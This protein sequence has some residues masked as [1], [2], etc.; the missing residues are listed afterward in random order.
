MLNITD[1]KKT[2]TVSLCD[3]FWFFIHFWNCICCGFYENNTR[4]DI[5]EKGNLFHAWSQFHE[6][7]TTTHEKNFI[8]KKHRIYKSERGRK[9]VHRKNRVLLLTIGCV[10]TWENRRSTR[11]YTTDF[12]FS[13]FYSSLVFPPVFISFLNVIHVFFLLSF[14]CVCVFMSYPLAGFLI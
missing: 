4:H 5:I 9:N 8:L 13:S 12:F 3:F 6:M 1:K 14:L 7:T 11:L 2:F 10:C